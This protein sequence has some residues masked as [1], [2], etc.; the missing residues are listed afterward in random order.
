MDATQARASLSVLL[1]VAKADGELDMEKKRV[2]DVVARHEY[3][4][5]EPPESRFVAGT[6][7][8]DRALAIIRAP[9]LRE[10]TWK[11]ALAIAS[12]DGETSEAEHALLVRIH[13]A[14]VPN[15]P[16]AEVTVAEKK[17]RGRLE[18]AED[19]I[20]EAT[21]DFLHRVSDSVRGKPSQKEYEALVSELDAKKRRIYSSTLSIL[22][23]G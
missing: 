18:Q 19:E 14:L 7:A 22:P 20:A 1:A 21:A 12:L 8:L 23:P 16:P 5:D 11:A 10:L 9:E 13:A 17:Y 2:L 6:D 3:E 4:D 15:A